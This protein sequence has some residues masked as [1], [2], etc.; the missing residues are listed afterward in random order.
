MTLTQCGHNCP[1]L[2]G[3]A[4]DITVVSAANEADICDALVIASGSGGTFDLTKQSGMND[5]SCSYGEANGI[6]P[7]G[8]YTLTVSAPGFA[9]STVSNVEVARD[10]C[11]LEQTTSRTVALA[12]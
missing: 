3:P 12:Q 10:D 1:G 9:T 6:L 11:N 4:F 5:A 8:A 7:A 2:E